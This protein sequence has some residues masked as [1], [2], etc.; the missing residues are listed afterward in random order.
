MMRYES[1]GL[2]YSEVLVESE[3]FVE[4]TEPRPQ[5][6]AKRTAN[7]ELLLQMLMLHANIVS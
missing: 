5:Q 4:I 3:V 1:V 2:F 6:Y 7:C